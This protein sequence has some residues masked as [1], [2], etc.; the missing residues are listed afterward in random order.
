MKHYC[1]GSLLLVSILAASCSNYIEK[2]SL[3]VKNI[4]GSCD[5]VRT[6]WH[7]D[8]ALPLNQGNGRFGTC[9]SQ[10][11][12]QYRPENRE[13]DQKYGNTT[14]LHLQHFARG[15][16]AT[17]YLLPLLRIYWRDS[18]QNVTDYQQHQSFYDGTITT[19]F[20]NEGNKM[21]VCSWFDPVDRDLACMTFK[22]DKDTTYLKAQRGAFGVELS[23]EA[24]VVD[25]H[26]AMRQHGDLLAVLADVLIL[27]IIHQTPAVYVFHARQHRVK[28]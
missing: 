6:T 19:T 28:M 27:G 11:G 23:A 15:K 10:D 26:Q 8:P 1:I 17:D 21:E 20:R 13:Q 5:I 24:F 18:L 12:L 25:Q 3:D 7:T 9:F 14:F 16:Y 2:D 4:V 22:G